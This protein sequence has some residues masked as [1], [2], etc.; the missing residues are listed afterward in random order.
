[1]IGT[2]IRTLRQEQGLTQ[3]QL[4]ERA[5]VKQPFVNLIECGKRSPSV[6]NLVNLATALGVTTD[7]LLR[8]DPAVITVGV[9]D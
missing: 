5:G 1:M 7:D 8:R 2:R 4:A 3:A 9:T 6:D